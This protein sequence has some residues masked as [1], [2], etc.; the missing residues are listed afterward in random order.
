MS[1]AG[2]GRWSLPNVIRTVVTVV[3]GGIGA[4]AGFK[5]THD[6]AVHHGQTGWLAWADAVVIEGMAVVTGFEIQR[7]RRQQDAGLR[8]PRRVTF[9]VVVL[10]VAFGIQ[11]A[12]QVALAERTPAGWL[13][14]A[15]PALG[16]LVVVKLLMR[17]TAIPE[18]TPSAGPALEAEPQ[19]DPA[20]AA[21]TTPAPA[22][23]DPPEPVVSAPDPVTEPSLTPVNGAGGSAPEARRVPGVRLPADVL[24][25]VTAAVE[26]ARNEG[27]QPTVADVRSAARIPEA[28]AERILADLD[29]QA[30][31]A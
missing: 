17:R 14:A 28:M 15:M 26:R 8:P 16:F 25:R 30:V 4:A 31:P 29:G 27:R 13:L 7:D 12:A 2:N 6:W 10:V 21:P 22:P 19:S 24:D 5:H 23:V 1:E 11:M 9:P 20:P 3:L 18:A